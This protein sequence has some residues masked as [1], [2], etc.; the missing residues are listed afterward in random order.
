MRRNMVD[1]FYP[2]LMVALIV[3]MD[4]I[5]FRH[6]FRERLIANVSLVVVFVVFYLIFLRHRKNT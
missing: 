6:R 2:A 3:S 4:L 5:F 1:I